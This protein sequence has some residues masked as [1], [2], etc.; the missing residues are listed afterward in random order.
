MSL[1]GPRPLLPVDQPEDPRLR[2]LVRPGV[3][4]WAQVIGGNSVSVEEK[5]ALDVWYIHHAAPL[6]DLKIIL[7]TLKVVFHGEKKHDR[8]I[9]EAV[10][11]RATAR[12]IDQQLFGDDKKADEHEPSRPRQGGNFIERAPLSH[13]T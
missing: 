3:T 8:E 2:L 7:R 1:I 10:Q 6:L 12:V 9:D 4:G 13:T 5:D 11:W